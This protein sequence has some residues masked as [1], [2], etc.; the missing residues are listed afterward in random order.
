MLKKHKMQLIWSS[1][2]ILLPVV[3]GLILWKALPEQF[4]THWNA[5]GEADGFGSKG[6]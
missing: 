6:R 5:A 4:T 1:V 2:V 3:A